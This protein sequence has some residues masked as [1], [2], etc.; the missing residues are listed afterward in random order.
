M[1]T[2]ADRT[3]PSPVQSQTG[4][5]TLINSFVVPAG[6]EAD[7]LNLWHATAAWFRTQPGYVAN[8]LHHAVSDGASYQFVNVV[9]WQ[10]EAEYQAAH[11]SP[12]FLRRVQVAEWQAFPSSPAL[13]EVVVEASASD[14]ITLDATMR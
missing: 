12:E 5:V 11:R 6:R 1:L 4:A 10:S 2:A 8:R 13:Y 9:Q 7:F 14:G 3:A